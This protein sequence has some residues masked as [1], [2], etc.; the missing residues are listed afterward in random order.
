M[1]KQCIYYKCD[2][3]D[4]SRNNF[5]SLLQTSK[6]EESTPIQTKCGAP[7]YLENVGQ[8]GI[9]VLCSKDYQQ[10][11]FLREA[12][13]IRHGM[14]FALQMEISKFQHTKYSLLSPHVDA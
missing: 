14:V 3:P 7:V 13:F 8:A 6:K 11:M 10:E 9:A 2:I 1:E 12:S 5:D 4:N